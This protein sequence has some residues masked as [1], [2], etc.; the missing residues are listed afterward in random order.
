MKPGKASVSAQSLPENLF[1]YTSFHSFLGILQSG[2]LQASAIQYLND[3]QELSHAIDLARNC[4]QYHLPTPRNEVERRVREHLEVNLNAQRDL[5]I[6]QFSF[7]E[8]GDLLSQ[9]RSYCPHSVGVC[10]SLDNRSLFDL[11]NFR[12][13][14]CIYDQSSQFALTDPIIRSEIQHLTDFFSRAL[15]T[16]VDPRSLE[17]D[18]LDQLRAIAPLIKDSS[19]AEERE[20]RL[21]SHLISSSDPRFSFHPSPSFLV[22]HVNLRIPDQDGRLP[23]K[24]V[25]VG[26]NPHAQLAMKSVSLALSRYAQRGWSVTNSKIPYRSF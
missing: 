11:P 21:V 24:Q 2:T 7:S 16:G 10:F 19:F 8:A 1:H 26:P 5:H 12:I 23:V 9:W 22:P 20:W 25:I 3:S 6:F 13:A 17:T 15:G 14:Q 18:W 4:I